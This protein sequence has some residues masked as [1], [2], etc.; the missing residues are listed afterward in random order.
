MIIFSIFVYVKF[1]Q[2]IILIHLRKSFGI[3]LFR[4]GYSQVACKVYE[5]VHIYVKVIR[6][7][8]YKLFRKSNDLIFDLKAIF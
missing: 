8:S 5:I 3:N 2:K 4:K 1:M 6:I 7:F